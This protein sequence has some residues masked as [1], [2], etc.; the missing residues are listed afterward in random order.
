[1]L[2]LPLNASM[3]D[4]LCATAPARGAPWKGKNTATEG[5]CIQPTLPAQTVRCQ[6]LR[7][8]NADDPVCA[9]CMLSGTSRSGKH[10]M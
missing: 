4:A 1:M 3:E 8:D 2:Q 10:R 5:L 6:Q 7:P 9:C